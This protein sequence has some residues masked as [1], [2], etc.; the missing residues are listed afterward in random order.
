MLQ[1]RLFRSAVE[2][3]QVSCHRGDGGYWCLRVAA[4]RGSEGW[5]TAD[6]QTYE[7]LSTDELEDTAAAALSV[8]LSPV[9]QR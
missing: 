2:D 3:V 7:V 9:D 5:D 4:R 1:D 6:V 8:A